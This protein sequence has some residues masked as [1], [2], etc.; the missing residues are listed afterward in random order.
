MPDTPETDPAQTIVAFDYGLRR[1][2]VAVGQRVTASASPLG[3][4][5]NTSSGPDW[6]AISRILGEW[7]PALLVV[8]MPHHADGTPSDM[9]RRAEDFAA[10]LARFELPVATVDE[11]HTS[12]EA[13]SK[14]RSQRAQGRRRRVRKET[15]D[16]AA[17]VLIAERW[18][19]QNNRPGAE[20]SE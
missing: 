6:D 20:L 4:V 18:L 1:I 3:V 12:Q 2:G 19:E 17:A 14:L 10:Q 16:S 15:I 8:G 13:E 5:S 7:R 11:R 9:S